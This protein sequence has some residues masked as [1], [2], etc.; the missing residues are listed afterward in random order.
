MP[1]Y[2]HGFD[3]VPKWHFS[4]DLLDG[5]GRD[6][7][8]SFA[9]WLVQNMYRGMQDPILPEVRPL[10]ARQKNA[11]K[12]KYDILFG[13]FVP[14]VSQ[15]FKDLIEDFAPGENYFYEIEILDRKGFRLEKSYYI[16]QLRT[17]VDSI[18]VEKSSITVHVYESGKKGYTGLNYG[19]YRT[20]RRKD[21]GDRKIWVEKMFP[22]HIFMSDDFYAEFSRRGMSGFRCLYNADL[23]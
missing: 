8:K 10:V 15:D 20:L 13:T 12:V 14:L 3:Y 22:E 21:V 6:V 9:F 19:D 2:H 23:E 18:I 4:F 11:T 7:S 16:M 17:R 1:L 5:E